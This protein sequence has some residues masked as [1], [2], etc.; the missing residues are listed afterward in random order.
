MGRIA[1]C[2]N[3]FLGDELRYEALDRLEIQFQKK[4]YQPD[5]PFHLTKK[6]ESIF[7]HSNCLLGQ[8]Q[9]ARPPPES[10]VKNIPNNPH[11]YRTLDSIP[12]GKRVNERASERVCNGVFYALGISKQLAFNECIIL[13]FLGARYDINRSI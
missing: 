2:V 9:A 13:L 4:P 10:G 7:S 11:T 6:R 5:C 1:R 3:F 8:K 12:Q